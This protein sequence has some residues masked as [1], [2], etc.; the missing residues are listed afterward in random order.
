MGVF[1]AL[2]AGLRERLSLPVIAAPMFLVSGPAWVIAACRA[3]VVGSF[4]TVNA[5]SSDELEAWLTEIDAALAPGDAGAGPAPY[6]ANLIVHRTSARLAGDLELVVRHRV[7]LVI[8]SVGH[9]GPVMAP[10]H[11]YGGLVFC[12]VASMRHVEKALEAGVDGLVLLC[13]GAGGQTGWINPFAFVRAVRAL[14]D[15]PVIVA[16]GIADGVSI[17]AV[18][19]LGADLAY[20]GTRFIATA[21]SL[22]GEA[23]RR[24]LVESSVDDILLTPAFT[25]LPGNMLRPSIEAAGLDPDALPARGKLEVEKDIDAGAQPKKRWRD[26]WSA[27]HGVG[28]VKSVL[29]VSDL[30]A[31]LKAEYEG[32]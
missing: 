3:G 24:M 31:E 18:E 7:P 22:A 10:V 32:G 16:G 25:G 11:D 21:E 6:A 23:Y 5:R 28:A 30:V 27:G 9:P 15:G 1:M 17:R 4:P 19:T 26:I 13:A 12:D 20:I 2:P 29:P 8:A 14:Y